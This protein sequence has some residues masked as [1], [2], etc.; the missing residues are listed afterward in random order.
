MPYNSKGHY[1]AW[2]PWLRW[3]RARL[4]QRVGEKLLRGL[5]RVFYSQSL[6]GQ[7]AILDNADFPFLEGFEKNWRAI[8]AEVRKILEHR[9][10]VPLFHEVSP[11]Q[12]M[13]SKGS[14]W[15]TFILYGFGT[16]LQRNCVQAPVTASLLDKVPN[17]Q[18]AWFSIL[19]P[20]YHIPSHKGVTSG[21]L[22]SHL[23]LIVPKQQ[24]KC[25]M[26]VGDNTCVWR[27]GEIFVFDDTYQHEVWNDTDEERVILIFDF[28]RPMRLW[29]RVLNGL[30][31][32]LIKFTAYYKE[33][34]KRMAAYEERFEA[35]VRRADETVEKLSDIGR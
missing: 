31:I 28:D 21:I 5:Q 3:R 26:Q 25:R 34:A 1:V 16:K 33:P 14:N 9:D 20:G 22:R 10:A 23:G 24:E 30:F 19:S 2:G 15:R 32:R 13:I 6:V 7:D 4:V 18:T 17:I 27:P 11:D 8:E 12:A 29:G 35:A